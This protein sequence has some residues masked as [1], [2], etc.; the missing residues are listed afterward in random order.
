M[1]EYLTLQVLWNTASALTKEMDDTAFSFYGTTLYGVE[2]QSPDEEQALGAVNGALGEALGKLYV[3]E[4]FPPEAKA[5]N[6]GTRRS[7]QGGHARAH[8]KT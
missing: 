5:Q 2:E 4:Y 7:H 1:K 6:R 3:E 8:R